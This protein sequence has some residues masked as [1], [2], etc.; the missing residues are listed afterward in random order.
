MKINYLQLSNILSFPH[1]D[2]V[3]NA[4]R[5]AFDDGMNIL[6]GENGA[7]KSTILEAITFFFRRAL[8][9]GYI[10]N[11]D[12]FEKRANLSL[13]NRR[14]IV[15]RLNDSGQYSGYRL[16]ANWA[17][18]DKPQIMRLSLRID[19]IDKENIR[20]ISAHLPKLKRL[21][22]IYFNETLV[23]EHDQPDAGEVI[24]TV[25][26]NRQ[27]QT[28]S[29]TFNRNSLE[30]TYIRRYNLFKQLI[31]IH[32][33]EYAETHIPQLHET[34]SLI[35]SYRNYYS[36]SPAVTLAGQSAVE[37]LRG[38]T[39]ADVMKSSSASD[40]AE[41]AV[42]NLVRLTVANEHFKLDG[43]SALT[44]EALAMA[45]D[46]PVMKKIN[47]KLALIGLK[48]FITISDRRTWQYSFKFLDTK[49]NT[50]IS[51]INS[52]S[53]GQKSIL[54]LVFEAYGRGQLVGGVSVID[55]PEIHLHYQFQHEYLRV[56]EDLME[57]QNTQYILVTHSESL[58]NSE[59]ISSVRRVSK[60]ANGS[61]TVKAPTASTA[62]RKLVKILDNNRSTYALFS[63]KVVLVEGD[64]DRYFFRAAFSDLHP[65]KNQEISVIDINGKGNLTQWR[66][67]FEAYGLSVYYIGDF[68]NVLTISDINGPI[69]TKLEE[70]NAT[71]KIKQAKL[72]E[73][74]A[75]T[76]LSLASA[77][78]PLL[79]SISDFKNLIFANWKP[80]IDRFL[81][82]LKTER[83][84]ILN[85][86]R[87][88][89]AD[90]DSRIDALRS[91]NVFILKKGALESYI[92][93]AHADLNHVI[94]YCDN[95]LKAWLS[96]GELEATEIREII[97][98]IAAAPPQQ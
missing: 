29:T 10:T 68:D 87:A 86:I 39:T 90:L 93:G 91:Q 1:H 89:R 53:A 14:Q 80:F 51:D 88:T 19:E 66:E 45:N 64:S 15:T 61:S 20:V 21:A 4:E 55:E 94:S 54:H 82:A 44:S 60:R 74:S 85:E 56:I 46:L 22:E 49:H 40:Q 11:M 33:I 58:I 79:P 92:G 26:L 37:Q 5:I 76:R 97:S 7:G 59:T 28:Y 8:M 63:Q 77:F 52:L 75:E 71:N 24:A 9:P 3:G 72:D 43:T 70:Q 36:F 17:T 81:N 42:F 2:D 83:I 25:Q 23:D 96:S 67:F 35:G 57:E 50:E 34:F 41:P 27:G 65:Q 30:S 13:D 48:A 12:N 62:R 78:S 16:D 73:L 47:G 38:I 6:I 95:N 31:Q 98:H 69:I 32:N 18:V 84:D